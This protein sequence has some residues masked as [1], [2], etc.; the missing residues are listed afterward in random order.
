MKKRLTGLIGALFLSSIGLAH[1]SIIY[2]DVADVTFLSGS[3][4][5]VNPYTGGAGTSTLSG[6]ASLLG[7]FGWDQSEYPLLYAVSSVRGSANTGLAMLSTGTEI[8]GS[9][10][11]G[12]TDGAYF[13]AYGG[14]WEGGGDGYTGFRMGTTGGFNYGYLHFNYDDVANILTLLDMAIE[15]TDNLAITAGAASAEVPEPSSIFMFIIGLFSLAICRNRRKSD[16][17]QL[18]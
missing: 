2:T 8:G 7:W 12:N 1:A 16:N 5:Q 6:G 17:G 10:L 14:E 4:L 3:T 13:E 15:T 11:F 18:A 9:S